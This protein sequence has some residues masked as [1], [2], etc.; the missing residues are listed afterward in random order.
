M[1]VLNISYGSTILQPIMSEHVTYSKYSTTISG[2]CA[3]R[4]CYCQGWVLHGA[5][6]CLSSI[7]IGLSHH[8]ITGLVSQS[9]GLA[10]SSCVVVLCLAARHGLHLVFGVVLVRCRVVWLT[11]WCMRV[12]MPGHGSPLSEG[13]SLICSWLVHSMVPCIPWRTCT[14]LVMTDSLS[15]LRRHYQ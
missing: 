5:G 11:D 6:L 3:I 4:W 8:C 14:I 12:L 1:Y 10:Y 2:S 13:D 9:G 7:R 15:P